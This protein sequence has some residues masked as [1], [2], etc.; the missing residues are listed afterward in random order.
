MRYPTIGNEY[1][2]W[3]WIL[4]ALDIDIPPISI[5]I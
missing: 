4:L 1:G 5:S 3:I 2:F